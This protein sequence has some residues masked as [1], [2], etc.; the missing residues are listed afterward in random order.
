MKTCVALLALLATVIAASSVSLAADMCKETIP[1]TEK[2]QPTSEFQGQIIESYEEE[3]RGD[4]LPLNFHPVAIRAS[5][6]DT[7]FGAG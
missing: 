6:V 4:D 5:A 3:G 2:G 7:P 1:V